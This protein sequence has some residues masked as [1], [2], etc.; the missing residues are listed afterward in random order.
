MYNYIIREYFFINIRDQKKVY[1]FFV[2]VR[3]KREDVD[4]GVFELVGKQR[5][6]GSGLC[7]RFYQRSEIIVVKFVVRIKQVIFVSKKC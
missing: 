4:F 3:V 7:Y 2:G 6:S 5:G 1:Y